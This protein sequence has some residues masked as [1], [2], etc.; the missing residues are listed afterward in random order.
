MQV[1]AD[2]YGYQPLIMT[3]HRADPVIYDGKTARK[4]ANQNLFVIPEPA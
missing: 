3:Y 2:V 1:S 4:I